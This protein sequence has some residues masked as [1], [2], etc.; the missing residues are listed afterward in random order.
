MS[1][2]LARFAGVFF[3]IG[4]VMRLAGLNVVSG[5]MSG[6]LIPWYDSIASSGW[7]SA[8]R[9]EY[10]NYPPPY[11]YLLTI[12]ARFNVFLPK[13][14]AVK[15]ISIFFDSVN[16]YLVYRIV[17]DRSTHDSL[18]MLAAGLFLCLPTVAVNSATWGQADAVFTCF[19]LASMHLLLQRRP[20]RAMILFGIAAAFKAQSLFLAP[21]LLLL[22]LKRRIPWWTCVLVPAAHLLAMLPAVIAGRGIYGVLTVYL[23]QARTYRSLS[24]NAPNPYALISDAFYGPVHV[25]GLAIAAVMALAWVL[26]YAR[27]IHAM[28]VEITILCATVAAAMMPFLLPKM[29]DRFFYLLDVF[30]F[31]LVF[32]LPSLWIVPVASQVASVSVYLIHL[33]ASPSTSPLSARGILLRVAV[34]VNSFAICFLLWKQWAI[35]TKANREIPPGSQ[36]LGDG[37]P[38]SPPSS[39]IRTHFPVRKAA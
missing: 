9:G 37:R 10:S 5:D 36:S 33:I 27:K 14:I 16:A 3:V 34:L 28:S 12:V 7:M 25:I 1:D 6:F 2:R 4:I 19:V 35:I 26:L 24:M 20:A 31:L 39:P 8:L 32:Y 23:E 29:H 21:F 30:S 22:T 18:P 13:A 17:K 15:L 38:G 11:L